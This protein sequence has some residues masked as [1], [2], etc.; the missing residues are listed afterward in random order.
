MGGGLPLTKLQVLER[1]ALEGALRAADAFGRFSRNALKVTS[2][3]AAFVD[4]ENIPGLQNDPEEVVIGVYFS[5]SGGAT[6][7]LLTFFSLEDAAMLVEAMLDTPIKTLEDLDE[8][9]MSLVGEAGNIIVSSFLAAL[10]EV[11]SLLVLPSPPAVAVD[12]RSAILTSAVLPMLEE[13]GRLLL[14]Q[15]R[16]E[17]TEEK[18]SRAASCRVLFLPDSDS[19]QVIEQA[20]DP[21]ETTC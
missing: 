20:F 21:K 16:I 3:Q 17:P 4:I 12:M 1:V 13:G 19:W 11:C 15:A 8:M 10:E 7:Y 14:M 18:A 2:A 6:G 5:I 9:E